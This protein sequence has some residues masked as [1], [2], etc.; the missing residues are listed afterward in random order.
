MYSVDPIYYCAQP[1]QEVL[2][3]GC[4]VRPIYNM[5]GTKTLEFCWSRRAM[6]GGKNVIIKEKKCGYRGECSKQ[7]RFGV[8]GSQTAEFCGKHAKEGRCDGEQTNIF[9][10]KGGGGRC[11]K[12]LSLWQGRRPRLG[13]KMNVVVNQLIASTTGVTCISGTGTRVMLP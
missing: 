13:N 11:T 10:E 2:R 6:S 12:H 9:F 1:L 7:R 4:I 8:N 5:A 3:R